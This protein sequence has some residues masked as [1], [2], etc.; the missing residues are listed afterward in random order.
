MIFGLDNYT[1]MEYIYEVGDINKN[2]QA[3]IKASKKGR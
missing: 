3:V 2:S 1:I